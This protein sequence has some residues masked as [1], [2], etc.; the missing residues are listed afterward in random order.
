METS[1]NNVQ[2]VTILLQGHFETKSEW[3]SSFPQKPS[4]LAAPSIFH[5]RI[6]FICAVVFLLW[7]HILVI[8]I[9][10]RQDTVIALHIWS[11]L[12]AAMAAKRVVTDNLAYLFAACTVK[13]FRPIRLYHNSDVCIL[14]KDM[15]NGFGYPFF[16]HTQECRLCLA[17]PQRM[18]IF[19]N[20]NMCVFNK[21]V[22]EKYIPVHFGL[23]FL[24]TSH[25][26]TR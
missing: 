5:N 7:L 12:P 3:C 24:H 8:I 26:A 15:E 17:N 13:G 10:K 25:C 23:M 16:E 22:Y 21:Y 11:F 9:Q 1:E 4:R 14:K 19:S 2:F 20:K 6:F 18:Q